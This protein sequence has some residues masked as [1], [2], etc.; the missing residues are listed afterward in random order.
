M[1][2]YNDY[3]IDTYNDIGT[4]D[5]SSYFSGG[6][7][8]GK[9]FGPGEK[10]AFRFSNV[11]VNQGATVQSAFLRFWVQERGGNESDH[12][13]FKTYGIKE[14]DTADLSSNPF[15]RTHTSTSDETDI[16]LP[17]TLQHRDITVTGIVNEIAGQGGWSSGNHM[18]FLLE[19]NGTD[20]TA[21][22]YDST[23]E[24]LLS[25][26]VAANPD[27][28]PGPYTTRV[29]RPPET[30]SYGVRISRTGKDALTDSTQLLNYFSRHNVLK[31][32]RSAEKGWTPSSN[33]EKADHGLK[34]NPA[35]LAFYKT[36][37]KVYHANSVSSTSGLP[38]GYVYSNQETLYF[39][40]DPNA[41]D[42]QSWFFHVFVDESV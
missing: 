16:V 5:G 4:D 12:I 18:G 27:F 32:L 9:R 37:N 14:T 25:I 17:P 39:L 20:G 3:F 26:L 40:L 34:Y 31:S 42:P 19:D 1:A 33:L 6:A 15:S 28:T 24:S 2:N 10:C 8:I 21:Y 29:N 35:F 7:E 23:L 36:G 38:I 13:R 22:I 30:R 41:S 11:Q